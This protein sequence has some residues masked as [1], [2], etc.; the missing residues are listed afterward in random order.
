MIFMKRIYLLALAALGTVAGFSQTTTTT[1]TTKKD[2]NE[3]KVGIRGS[4]NFFSFGGTTH[5]NSTLTGRTSY[6]ADHE[7]GWSA[8]A[9]VNI[10][11]G[12][13]AIS[14]EPGVEYAKKG[15]EI[16]NIGGNGGG[17]FTQKLTYIDAP[18]VLRFG[19]G[20]AFSI[21]A[22]PQVSFLMKTET[23][24]SGNIPTTTTLVS[25]TKSDYRNQVLGGR[26]GI[27]FSTH[28][29]GIF[30]QY[31]SDFQDTFKAHVNSNRRNRG[32]QVGLSYVF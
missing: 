24:R 29:I 7:T 3:V 8:G 17:K 21:Y 20:T 15:A 9:F 16:E 25:E 5:T 30:A 2:W 28:H 10:P 32:A 18:V 11:L 4:A 6:D 1:S 14:I 12:T 27:Q 22:G 19:L 23:E 13:K 26:A 31:Q